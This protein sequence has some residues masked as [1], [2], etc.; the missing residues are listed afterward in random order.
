MESAVPCAAD[1]QVDDRP[2]FPVAP[3]IPEAVL[4]RA[5]RENPNDERSFARLVSLLVHATAAERGL[6]RKAYG[7]V[8]DDVTWSLA[9]ELARRPS[10]WFPLLELARLSLDQD[11][12]SAL[13]RLGIAVQREP[14]GR[15]LARAAA[16]LRN[17]GHPDEAFRLAVAQWRP[18]QHVLAAGRQLVL[19]GLEAGREAE[20]RRHLDALATRPGAGH[21]RVLRTEVALRRDHRR[22]LTATETVSA[23]PARTA[24]RLAWVA[25]R[26]GAVPGGVP[27]R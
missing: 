9:T 22:R 11:T 27:C 24:A 10:A 21:V 25:S 2:A 26:L 13:R 16:L 18:A 17:A 8:T 23:A 7:T 19:A 3:K 1:L 4:H 20:L 14:T 12:E 15:G 6:D 5:L